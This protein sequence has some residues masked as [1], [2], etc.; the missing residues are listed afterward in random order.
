MLKALHHAVRTRHHCWMYNNSAPPAP[1]ELQNNGYSQV[2]KYLTP[3]TLYPPLL[4]EYTKCG[5]SVNCLLCIAFNIIGRGVNE[6][7]FNSKLA[8]LKM[9]ST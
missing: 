5:N 4:G 3:I 8:M 1:G 6:E 7:G 9:C 2:L